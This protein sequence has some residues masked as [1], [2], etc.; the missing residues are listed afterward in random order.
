MR[1]KRFQ[2]FAEVAGALAQKLGS[3]ELLDVFEDEDAYVAH[4]LV[5]DMELAYEC[6]QAATCEGMIFRSCEFDHVDFRDS[7]FRDVRFENCRFINCVMDKGWLNRVDF[8]GCSAPGLSLLQARLAGVFACDTDFSY[9]N[10][11]EVSVDQLRLHSCRLRETALQRA[12][13]KRV[14]FDECDL[15]GMDVFGTKLAD[16]DFSTS[17]FQAP[18]LSGDYHELRGI[19]VAPEQAIELAGLLGVRVLDE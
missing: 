2:G 18:V 16:I 7:T 6:T 10:F 11:S 1:S 9:A 12:K 19:I 13:L 4:A 5:E 3:D 8:V 15:T 17:I 14:S